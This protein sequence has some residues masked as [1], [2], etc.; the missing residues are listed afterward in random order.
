TINI[1][2]ENCIDMFFVGGSL[3]TTNNLSEIIATIKDHSNLPVIIFPGST[4]HIDMNAD[5]IL[6]LSLLSGRNPDLLIGQ[7]VIAAPI[8]KNSSLEVIST[9]YLLINSDRT[10]SVAYMSNTTP[11]PGDKY[12][13]AASTAIA[14]EMLGSQ[15]IY[16]DAGSGGTPISKTMIAKVKKAI[17]IPLII[18]GGINSA[19]KA[20]DALKAGAD[21]IVIGNAAEKN[22][23]LLIEVSDKIYELNKSLDIH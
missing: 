22:P 17:N 6:F 14:G 23:N 13:I 15:L 4:M 11:I 9:G 19:A 20:E 5:G 16:L 7:H 18:G 3:I 12:S 10:T 8:L 1:A 21:I 2:Q